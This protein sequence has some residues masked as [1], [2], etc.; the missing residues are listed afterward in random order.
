[1]KGWI[2]SAVLHD[3]LS[4]AITLLVWQRLGSSST[5]RRRCFQH[6]VD[7]IDLVE[8]HLCLNRNSLCAVSTADGPV[9]SNVD[10]RSVLLKIEQCGLHKVNDAQIFTRDDG[11]SA[12]LAD[13][14]YNEEL[15]I[16]LLLD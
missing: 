14:A 10:A 5:Y 9:A 1:M 15:P 11:G 12:L 16:V 6:L 4:H 13:M 7:V 2:D 8:R 3:P